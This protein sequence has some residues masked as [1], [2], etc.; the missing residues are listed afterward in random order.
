MPGQS[1]PRVTTAFI[2]GATPKFTLYIS[3]GARPN[4][5]STADATIG[6]VLPTIQ[7]SNRAG[8]AGTGTRACGVK[9]GRTVSTGTGSSSITEGSCETVNAG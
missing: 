9:I 7:T 4:S 2:I 3:I 5:A 8:R 1:H 6:P